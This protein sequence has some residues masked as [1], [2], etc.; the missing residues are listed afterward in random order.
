MASRFCIYELEELVQLVHHHGTLMMTLC[1]LDF[2]FS[3]VATLGNLLVT[4]ALWKASSISA[5]I[6]KL[7]LSLAF[8]DLA[9][10]MFAQLVCGASIAV[11]LRMKAT[12][13]YNFDLLCP[14]MLTVR[15]SSMFLLGCASFLNVTAIALDRLLAISLHLR[16]QELVT[17]KRATIA[18]VS[19]WFACGVGASVYILVPNHKDILV[20]TSQSVVILVT[21]VAY[22]RIYNIVKHHRNQIQSQLQ[23]TNAEAVAIVREKKSAFNVLFV[24]VV[25]LA[26]YLPYLCSVTLLI[27]NSLQISYLIAKHVSMFLV[28]LNSSLNPTVYCWRYREVR[29]IVFSTTKAILRINSTGT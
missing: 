24:Y 4:Y 28:L 5:T 23:I 13:D 1:V 25:F 26:C 3:L 14:A 22:I 16:Y 8:S 9:A 7:L 29:N 15:C 6:K 27:T 19:L 20:S 17:S 18:L 21:T 11:M 2:I 10:G 12:G